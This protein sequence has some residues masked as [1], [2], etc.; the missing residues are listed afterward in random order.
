L[1]EN[2]SGE[3]FANRYQLLEKLAPRGM[4]AVVYRARDAR[5]NRIVALKV[6]LPECESDKEKVRRFRQEGETA[7]RLNHDNIIH[8]YDAHLSEP[9]YYIAMEWLEG[10]P[11]GDFLRAQPQ[12]RLTPEAA[13]AI[14]RQ[15]CAALDYAHDRHVIHR[16]IKPDNIIRDANGK[17]TLIDFGIARATDQTSATIDGSV[18]GTLYYMSPEQAQGHTKPPEMGWRTD[19]Y[20]LGAVLYEMLTGQP[21]FADRGGSAPTVLHAI[22]YEMPAQLRAFDRSIPPA[23]QAVVMKA[24]QKDREKRFQSG[25]EMLKAYRE[26]IGEEPPP[27][28]P[29]P[30]WNKWLLIG[31]LAAVLALIGVVSYLA[32]SGGGGGRGGSGVE[33]VAVPPVVGKRLRVAE[34]EL[35]KASLKWTITPKELSTRDDAIVQSAT[36]N[37]KDG[38]VNLRVALE[39]FHKPRAVS[40]PKVVGNT[41]QEAERALKSAQLKWTIT[42]K[43]LS[44]RLGAVVTSSDP[45]QGEKVDNET[46]IIHLVVTAPPVKPK[47]VLI[48]VPDVTHRDL[49]QASAM[50]RGKGFTNLAPPTKAF[51]KTVG[52]GLVVSED[53]PAGTKHS[54]ANPISLVLSLG[55]GVEVPDLARQSVA[56]AE[57]TLRSASLKY[58]KAEPVFHDT[59]PHGHVVSQ[60]PSAGGMLPVGGTVR[61]HLS[62]GPGVRVPD[63]S[64]WPLDEAIKALQDKGLKPQYEAS[65][66]PNNTVSKTR[67]R[68]GQRV[69]YRSTVKIVISKPGTGGGEVAHEDKGM[70]VITAE[71]TP[72]ELGTHQVDV[73]I[74]NGH[75]EPLRPLRDIA[76]GKGRYHLPQGE[77]IVAIRPE[78]TCKRVAIVSSKPTTVRCVFVKGK[79]KL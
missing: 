12:G 69:A 8:I 65:A 11:L 45:K 40:V 79:P 38:C 26:A 43:D 32:L 1:D 74:E 77:W 51:S 54:V 60:V 49:A 19:L 44:T 36:L 14:L 57:S 56:S 25:A 55:P 4:G 30:P 53:P 6:L 37:P 5:L 50:L 13:E 75:Q 15:V 62:R 27:F 39:P 41:L 52:Q 31:A 3:L 64:G 33:G 16:D 67:P 71:G 61:V 66:K 34:N 68:A 24:L 21:S 58:F 28:P 72:E 23:V 73:Y 78:G 20:S 46:R 7:A 17:V 22:V 63:L 9:P 18:I 76:D 2:H 29:P 42:P 48:E 59:I 47:K 10:Q 35:R 70:L